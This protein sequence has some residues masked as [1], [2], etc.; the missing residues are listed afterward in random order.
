MLPARAQGI[1]VAF[2][3][4]VLEADVVTYLRWVL[5]SGGRVTASDPSCDTVQVL[6][7]KG[8]PTH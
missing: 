1:P 7:E 2:P 3:G 8:R 4:G 6:S 5:A